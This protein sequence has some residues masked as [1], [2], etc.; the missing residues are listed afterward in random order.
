MGANPP[1]AASQ[2]A[3]ITR[4]NNDTTTP[5]SAAVLLLLLVSVWWLLFAEERGIP[6]LS[7]QGA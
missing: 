1:V 4:V 2:I 7:T 5:D 6:R 3:R